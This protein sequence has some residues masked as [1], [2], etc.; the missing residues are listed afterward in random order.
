MSVDGIKDKRWVTSFIEDLRFKYNGLLDRLL[1]VFDTYVTKELPLAR[2]DSSGALYSTPFYQGGMIDKSLASSLSTLYVG[3]KATSV[4]YKLRAGYAD[5]AD[6]L[7]GKNS[8][9][10]STVS[11]VP[12]RNASGDINTRLFR[13]E[14]ADGATISGA[15]A[16]RINNSSDNYIRFCSDKAAIRSYLGV[17]ANICK[18]VS[19]QNGGTGGG[20][21]RY[22]ISFGVTFTTIPLVSVMPTTY[23]SNE[24]IAIYSLS[25][26]GMQYEV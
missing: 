13:S 26:S 11:T 4:W 16:F 3:Y 6:K 12:V 20:W 14:Y 5:D 23:F 19:G 22:T 9:E 2:Y 24:N 18:V 15:M 25:A 8:A 17:G 1:A 21:T 10:A 7:D